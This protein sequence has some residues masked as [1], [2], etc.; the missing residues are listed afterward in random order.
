M[1]AIRLKGK[2][3]LSKRASRTN[4]VRSDGTASSRKPKKEKAAKIIVTMKDRDDTAYIVAA[5]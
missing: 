3:V 4:K 2:P 5:I 1:Q